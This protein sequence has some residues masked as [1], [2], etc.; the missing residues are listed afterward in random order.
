MTV[1][2]RVDETDTGLNQT[3]KKRYEANSDTN[4]FTDA[5]KTK[6]AGIAT[7]ANAYTHPNHSGDV[8]STGDGATV[9]ANNAVTEAKIASGAVT[10]NKLGDDAVSNA[11]LA[12]MANGTIKGRTSSGTGDPED[13]SASQVRTVLSVLTSTQ[14]ASTANGEGAALIGIED[15]GTN[16][17]G[18]TVEAALTQL[19]D[20]IDDVE[21]GLS[22]LTT[23][24][25][26]L[27]SAV[28][29]F[30]DAGGDHEASR[31]AVSGP[32]IWIDHGNEVPENAIEGVDIYTLPTAPIV[33][34]TET[35]TLLPEWNGREVYLT[36]ASPTLAI[37]LQTS[38][39]YPT[40]FTCGVYAANA[41]VLDAAAGVD[42]NGG[43][44]DA[45]DCGA[46]PGAI[47]V[48]RVA[49]DDWIVFGTAE[50]I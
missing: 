42:L 29:Y 33:V 16:F 11:K 41:F 4:A 15:A 14:L 28:V 47:S 19:A 8:T 22:S 23:T 2:F 6:L 10:V 32:V 36:H 49:E 45:F 43:D 17:S 31:P 37:A 50:A 13:L 48:R 12:N 1:E 7:G 44:G 5:E 34:S 18:E 46:L 25:G 24:V 20:E 9:I 40:G 30:V 38:Q 27:Q 26:T 39:T 35:P 3:T 21:S